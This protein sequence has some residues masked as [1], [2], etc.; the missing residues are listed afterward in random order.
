[1]PLERDTC[2][3]KVS[4]ATEDGKGMLLVNVTVVDDAGA[5]VTV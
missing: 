4:P 2:A 3:N 5:R 1:M